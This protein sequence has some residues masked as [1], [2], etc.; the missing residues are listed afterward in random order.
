MNCCIA[1]ATVVA[2]LALRHRFQVG[3]DLAVSLR[4]R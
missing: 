4:V 3:E 1:D 2:D